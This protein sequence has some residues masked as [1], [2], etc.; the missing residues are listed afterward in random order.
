MKEEILLMST[1]L[2]KPSIFVIMKKNLA[3]V[4]L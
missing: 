3:S 4:G 2:S 1:D